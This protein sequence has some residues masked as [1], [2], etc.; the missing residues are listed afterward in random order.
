MAQMSIDRRS[1]KVLY[2]HPMDKCSASES[3]ELLIKE[4]TPMN[5]KNTMLS[6]RSLT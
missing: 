5:L 4:T 3:K 1:N 2:N 6:V